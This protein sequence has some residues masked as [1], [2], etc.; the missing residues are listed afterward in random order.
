MNEF[1]ILIFNLQSGKKCKV[2]QRHSSKVEKIVEKQPKFES[3]SN[4]NHH[5]NSYTVGIE[6]EENKEFK[7]GLDNPYIK[8]GYRRKKQQITSYITS[9]FRLHNETFNIWS[10]F[11]GAV[12]FLSLIISASIYVSKQ[13]LEHD[14]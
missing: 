14:K 3:D 8:F 6:H 9:M 2:R 10:H 5:A 4:A 11:L 7:F 12:L 1:L 13:H